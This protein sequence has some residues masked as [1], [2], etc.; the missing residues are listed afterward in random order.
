MSKSFLKYYQFM[1]KISADL[2]FTGLVGYGLFPEKLPPIFTSLSW[3]N[4]CNKNTTRTGWEK[5]TQ[6]VFYE[7]MRNTNVPRMMGIPNPISYT[8]LCQCLKEYW[9]DIRAYFKEQTEGQPYK[10]SRIHIRLKKNDK[11]LF[12]MNYGNPVA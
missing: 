11:T 2:L 3:L 8:V 12:H 9:S 5:P 10:K 4:F 6:Y 7:S 1:D